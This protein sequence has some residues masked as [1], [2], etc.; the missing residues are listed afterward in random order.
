MLQLTDTRH[1]VVVVNPGT[2]SVDI[3]HRVV[4]GCKGLPALCRSIF[5]Y[6]GTVRVDLPGSTF[7]Q[8]ELSKASALCSTLHL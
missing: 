1:P 3:V 7:V 2:T 4:L 5:M 6:P 8:T